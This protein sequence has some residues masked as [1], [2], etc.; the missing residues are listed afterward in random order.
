MSGIEVLND[1]KQKK[2][3]KVIAIAGG[4]LLVAYGCYRMQVF[5]II[6]GIIILLSALFKKYSTVNEEGLLVNYELWLFK[7]KEDWSFSK[8]TEMHRETVSDP[9]YKV[10]H[11]TK[12][13]MSRRVLLSSA[14]AKRVVEMAKSANPSIHFDEAY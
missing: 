4:I 8:L 1:R 3:T 10:L 2:S 7:Y 13:A 5:V 9:N 6:C 11:F 14:D 12:G